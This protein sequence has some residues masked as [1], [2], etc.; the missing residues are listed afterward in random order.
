MKWEDEF[1]RFTEQSSRTRQSIATEE[2]DELEDAFVKWAW[3][4]NTMVALVNAA[5]AYKKCL[6][7]MGRRLL[8]MAVSL[9]LYLSLSLIVLRIAFSL[10]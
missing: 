1:P 7:P 9:S 5:C 2:W 3:H 10:L 8:A 4:Q 6:P